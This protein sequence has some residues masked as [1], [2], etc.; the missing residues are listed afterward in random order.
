MWPGGGAQDA[1][2]AVYVNFI[3]YGLVLL[4]SHYIEHA[5]SKETEI[6]SA[7]SGLKFIHS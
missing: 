4:F 3:D 1:V 2:I 5:E 7:S 6:F